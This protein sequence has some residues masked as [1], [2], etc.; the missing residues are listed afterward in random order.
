MT[1]SEAA[2]EMNNTIQGASIR[3]TWLLVA[4]VMSSALVAQ[5]IPRTQ[6]ETERASAEDYIASLQQTAIEAKSAPWGY[7]GTSPDKYSGWT[8]HSNRLIPVY[9]FGYPLDGVQGE[10]SAY[11]DQARIDAIYGR[12]VE[13]SLNTEADYFD[14]IEL[15]QLQ[16]EAAAA[17][18]KYIVVIVFD[19]MDWQTTWAAA[20]YRNRAVA[21]RKGRGRGL[22]FQDYQGVETDFGFMVTSPWNEDM[23]FDVDSQVVVNSEK[24]PFGGYNAALSGA[25]A[26]AEPASLP[27]LI[28]QDK[29][30][31][32]AVT[33]S[34]SS[35][36]SMFAGIKSYNAAI[37]VAPD[38]GK[39]VP[40]AREL[41]DQGWSV[42]VVTSVPISH[43]TP[44]ATWSNNV[45]RNDYQDLSRDLVGLPSVA[46]RTALPGVD[47]LIGGGWGEAKTSESEVKSE[48][49]NQGDNF[50]PG[51]RYFADSDLEA[52]DVRNGGPYRVALRTPGARGNDVL[53]KA[54]EQAVRDGQRLFGMFGV[55]RGQLP[56]ATANGDYKPVVGV[57]GIENYVDADIEENPTL[58][59]MTRAALKVLETNDKGFWLMVESGDVDWA[60][61][62]NQID[63]SI[64]AVFSGE[65]AFEEICRWAEARDCW[66]ETAVFVTADHGHLLVIT[67]PESLAG[68]RIGGGGKAGDPADS[69]RRP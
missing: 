8:N 35:A 68:L 56:Y 27:S 37:N 31:V 18:K 13:E 23:E 59:E 39:V 12:P 69:D 65:A 3:G 48:I 4:V 44:A 38:G 47:V 49:R 67:D 58:A 63:N 30:L 62:D 1:C 2:T 26:W 41:K 61:H 20:L 57:T 19:G 36:T 51:N 52:I 34:A 5:E 60:N 64:G 66:N 9:S 29:A 7:W 50:A 14:Q 21:Y 33:D 10:Q 16:K 28:G 32:H 15:Y 24:P 54:A 40:V 46:N 17:G 45:S 43:A 25:T 6:D 11:R 53:A 22:A 42:G 55:A